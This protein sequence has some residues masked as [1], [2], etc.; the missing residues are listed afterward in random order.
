MKRFLILA[1]CLALMPVLG[2]AEET[3]YY[4]NPNG[5]QFYHSQ[6]QCPSMN[7]S[8]WSQ[9][10]TMTQDRLSQTSYTACPFCVTPPAEGVRPHISPWIAGFDTASDIR[11]NAAGLYRTGTDLTAGIYTAVTDDQ[12][13]GLLIT[14]LN[15]GTVI[16]EFPIHGEASYSFYLKDGMSVTLPE[17]A[18]LTPIVKR[19]EFSPEP[20]TETIRQGRRMLIYEMQPF[21]YA[22]KAIEGEEGCIILCSLD[23]EF[24]SSDPVIIPLPAGATVTF[25]TV[26]NGI[27][28]PMPIRYFDDPYNYAYFIE[29]INCVVWPEDMNNG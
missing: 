18:V 6:A 7:E 22:A 3:V 26:M 4:V 5:G 28:D 13:D 14:A 17:H 21:V 2:A 12:C 25:D 19:N 10:L 8:Y 16:H 15:D 29:F 1:L 24:G 23:A 27:N 20:E 9:L 11:M